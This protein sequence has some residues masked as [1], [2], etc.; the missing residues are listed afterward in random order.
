[1]SM[2]EINASRR[3]RE[4]AKEKAEADK[5]AGAVADPARVVGTC[6]KSTSVSGA[7]SH[8]SAMTRPPWLGRAV[9]NRHRHAIEQALR[10]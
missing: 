10:R 1:M 3:L 2:N 4:A 5:I 9:R 7:L 6:V 8:F